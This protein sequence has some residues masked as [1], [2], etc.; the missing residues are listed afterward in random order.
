[1]SG[2]REL[3]R[4]IGRLTEIGD[5]L[6]AMRSLALA[7]SRRIAG[8]IDAQRE[9]SAIVR[10]AYGRLLR[11]HGERLELPAPAGRVVCVIGSERGFCGDLNRRLAEDALRTAQDSS[12]RWLLV[13]SRLADAWP[14]DAPATVVRLAGAG[15]ADEVLGVQA[16]L[17]AALTPLLAPA[18]GTLPALIVHAAGPDGITRTPLL[19]MPDEPAAPPRPG[20]PVDL[21]LA[22]HRLLTALLD[23]YLDVSLAGVLLDALLHENEQRLAHMEQARRNVDE[24][25]DALARRANRARQEEI[26]EEIEVI[27]LASQPDPT[28]A[29]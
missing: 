4:H 2:R 5:L 28:P 27:L 10:A 7:E 15:M 25:L 1:M 26:T 29:D 23:P 24:H 22:P 9:T 17:F 8:F 21:N 20:H 19:P 14:D 18:A 16:A 13:G 12:T 11:D 6:G 3:L